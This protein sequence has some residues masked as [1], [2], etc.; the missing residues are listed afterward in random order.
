MTHELQKH[1]PLGWLEGARQGK[2]ESYNFGSRKLYCNI[3]FHHGLTW[4]NWSAMTLLI[5]KLRISELHQT[6]DIL[7]AK[8]MAWLL[9]FGY[10]KS[11]STWTPAA[12]IHTSLQGNL[13]LH[14]GF[15]YLI[16]HCCCCCWWRTRIRRRGHDLGLSKWSDIALGM[17]L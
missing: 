2:K 5:S 15:S 10:L 3:S 14:T 17:L 12:Q 16:R 11:S 1:A 9:H 13:P 4:I 7:I 8:I 6:L